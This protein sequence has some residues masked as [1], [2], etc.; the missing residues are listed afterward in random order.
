MNNIAIK[1]EFRGYR[2][3]K[4]DYLRLKDQPMSSFTIGVKK[5]LWDPKT[6]I[7]ELVSELEL[8]FGEEKSVVVFSIG[9]KIIDIEWLELMAEQTIVNELFRTGFPY[10]SQKIQTITSDFRPGIILP[11]LDL[12]KFDFTKKI[13]FNLNRVP[14]NQQKTEEPEIIN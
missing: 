6:G 1:Y 11:V 10:V 4:I 8:Y 7:Y 12:K 5:N 3:L 9:Y 14:V 13:V 2:I